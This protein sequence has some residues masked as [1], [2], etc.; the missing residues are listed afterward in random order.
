VSVST[1]LTLVQILSGLGSVSN[2]ILNIKADVEKLPPESAAPP[3]HVAALKA[4]LGSGGSVWDE[5]HAGE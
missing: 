3:E 2:A 5:T 4:A 1:L